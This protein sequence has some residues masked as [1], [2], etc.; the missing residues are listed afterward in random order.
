MDPSGLLELREAIRLVG[1]GLDGMVR[2]EDGSW[3]TGGAAADLSFDMEQ[4]WQD[5]HRAFGKYS[6][7]TSLS[8]PYRKGHSKGCGGE[9]RSEVQSP[10]Y[11][12]P[13]DTPG[14]S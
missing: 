3:Y 13:S 4:A 8:A 9:E 7:R 5:A 14:R 2:N 12:E 11:G 1:A 10:L 6:K